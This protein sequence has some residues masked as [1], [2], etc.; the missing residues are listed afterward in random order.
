MRKGSCTREPPVHK[1]GLRV[2]GP[3]ERPCDRS[4]MKNQKEEASK[5]GARTQGP[6]HG[7]RPER[8][9]Q[10]RM[11]DTERLSQAP[12]RSRAGAVAQAT[13]PN[14]RKPAKSE[15]PPLSGLMSTTQQV[16]R[17]TKTWSYGARSQEERKPTKASLARPD[18]GLT[19]GA[20]SARTAPRQG[21]QTARA[22]GE[23]DTPQSKGRWYVKG[24]D[25]NNTRGNSR[26]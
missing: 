19:D 1:A 12:G 20:F 7:K 18:A 17:H 13:W 15:S 4:S 25:K 10:I 16:T 5:A 11:R 9:R 14:R 26:V 6:P 22:L 3:Q 24:N 21:P 2:E 23:R 8:G